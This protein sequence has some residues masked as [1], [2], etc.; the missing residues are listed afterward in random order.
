M[1]PRLMVCLWIRDNNTSEH[2]LL[3]RIRSI[4]ATKHNGDHPEVSMM[5]HD[6]TCVDDGLQRSLCDVH[7]LP[8]VD[9]LSDIYQMER[10][11][12]C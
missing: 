10:N 11:S 6:L 1:L 4:S 7:L 9:L 5:R 3:V 2:K 12:I 8:L